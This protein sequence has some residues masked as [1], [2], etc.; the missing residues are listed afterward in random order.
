MS[1]VAATRDCLA[2][3]AG[4]NQ[5]LGAFTF[6]DE[7]GALLSAHDSDLRRSAGA[8]LGP[9]DGMPVAIKANIAVRNWPLTAGLRFRA[10]ERATEDAYSVTRLRDAGAVLV[11]LTNM[12]EGALGAE[13]LNPWYGSSHNPRRQGWSAGGSSSGA[14]VAVAA[15]L[16]PVAL[17]TDTIGSLR[18]PASFCGV[19]SLKP[20]YG[21]ISVRGVVPV[22]LRFDHVGPI[23]R[24]IRLLRLAL[25]VLAV[26]DP[27]CR[28]SVPLAPLSARPAGTP[29]KI[30][31][32]VGMEGYQVT[33]PVIAAYNRGIAALRDMGHPLTHVDLSRWDLPRLRRA[34]LTLCELEMWRVH[35]QRVAESPDDFSDGLRAFI[36]YGGKLDSD[37]IASAE[38]RIAGFCNQWREA[39]APFDVCILPSTACASFP[40]RERHPQNTADLTSIASATG[41]PALSLPLPV[42]TDE[43]PV[44][45]QLIGSVGG[46]H[47]LLRIAQE[48]ETALIPEMART[49]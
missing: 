47:E 9:L 21:L 10:Q 42:P 36:R 6:I 40:Q 46:D 28:V 23:A 4:R 41:L 37:D 32:A 24:D 30:A 16:V 45:L 22:H 18:I 3:I 29:V 19:A 1:S 11:G 26:H 38:L 8:S 35:R 49:R 20:S 2:A 17:G 15:G 27:P 43:M 34:I 7:T 31:Y 5:Q 48:L 44:G 39:M 13:G 12:D 14:A 25:E 33:P